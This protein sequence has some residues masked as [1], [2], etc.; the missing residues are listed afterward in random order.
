[1]TSNEPEIIEESRITARGY[2]HRM[3]IPSKIFRLLK[4]RDKD[5]LRWIV[6]GDGTIRIIK[7]EKKDENRGRN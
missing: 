1:M 3:T 7:V 5:T 4:L 2:R 6:Y